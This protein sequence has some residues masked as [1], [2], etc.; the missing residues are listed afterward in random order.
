MDKKAETGKR[1]RTDQQKLARRKLILE[2]A[3][4]Q[5]RQSGFEGFSMGVLARDANV[6]KGTLYLYFKTRE[7]V[8]L[9]IYNDQ[10]VAWFTSLAASLKVDM[11]DE[12]F[13]VAF[14][15]TMRGDPV[16]LELVARLDSVI[17]HNV[18]LPALI[19]SKQLMIAQIQQLSPII[20]QSLHL[21]APQ[22][23]ELLAALAALM[24]GAQQSDSGPSLRAE[25]LPLEVREL[26]NSFAAE[27][28]FIPNACRI[29][30][31][32]RSSK[33]D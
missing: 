29:L 16:F 20:Q 23:F 10:L 3:E 9:A 30:Q 15:E 26:V 4:K 6:A 5:F 24:L 7:E 8:L 18:S 2:A 21:S 12:A 19:D 14:F 22:A 13:A 11:G 33:A 31:G 32:M 1:A 28:I 17:E 27:R 25:K